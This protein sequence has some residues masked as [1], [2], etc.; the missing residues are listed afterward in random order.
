[1]IFIFKLYFSSFTNF[2]FLR[3]FVTSGTFVMPTHLN[4]RSSVYLCNSQVF[5]IFFFSE[6][7]STMAFLLCSFCCCNHFSIRRRSSTSVFSTNL[8]K[9]LTVCMDFTHFCSHANFTKMPYQWS[10]YSA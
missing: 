9:F 5:S 6:L 4:T 7:S 8:I 3:C 1:M 2:R 10:L